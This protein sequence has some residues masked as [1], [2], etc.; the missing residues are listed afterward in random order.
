[1]LTT[2]ALVPAGTRVDPVNTEDYWW[3]VECI[4]EGSQGAV[5]KVENDQGSTLALKWYHPAAATDEQWRALEYL[6]DQDAP[7]ER[8]LWPIDLVS[9]EGISGFGYLMP[10]RDPDF[11]RMSDVVSRRRDISFRIACTVGLH[12]AESFLMLHSR[13]LCYR[14]ISFGNVFLDPKHGA[15]LI[16]DVDNVGIDGE[17][18][19]Q[20]LGTPYFMAPEILTGEALPSTRTDQFSL[21]VLL[22]FLF[23]NHHP[24]EGRR[25]LTFDIWDAQAQLEVFGISPIFIFDP[26]DDSNRPVAGYQDAPLTLWPVYPQLLRDRFSQSFGKGLVDAENGRVADSLWRSDMVR[27]RDSIVRC[28]TCSRE[29]FFDAVQPTVCWSCSSVVPEPLRL[30]ITRGIRQSS[31]AAREVVLNDDT[32][33]YRHHIA[34]DYDFGSPVAKVVPHPTK[35]GFRGLKNLGP[36]SWKA[37]GLNGRVQEGLPGSALRLVP[38]IRFRAGPVWAEIVGPT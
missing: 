19:S 33:I 15:I 29:N 36:G 18:D 17:D 32:V 1:M 12:L 26:Y 34:L 28:P 13:G 20:V 4:G 6:L 21:A 25:A 5:F 7:S 27:I 23:I 35:E 16:C 11:V 37:T 9:I 14:D 10:L 24:L 2:Q 31:I 22:F 3:V 30:R 8:F 38:G